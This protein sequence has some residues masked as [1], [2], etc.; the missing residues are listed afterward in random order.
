MW[1]RFCPHHSGCE[2]IYYKAHFKNVFK[3]KRILQI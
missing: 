1:A 2:I 3:L